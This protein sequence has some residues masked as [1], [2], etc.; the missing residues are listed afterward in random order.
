[1]VVGKVRL[2]LMI[3]MW[4]GGRWRGGG[5]HGRECVRRGRQRTIVHGRGNRLTATNN[6]GRIPPTVAV[7]AAAAARE[8]RGVVVNQPPSSLC[9]S[10]RGDGAR[11]SKD[12]RDLPML[13]QPHRNLAWI[14]PDS[15]HQL[16]CADGC[17]TF[18]NFCLHARQN[19]RI[20]LA[21]F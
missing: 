7:T 17:G 5:P 20:D 10:K 15:K 1:M 14:S 2:M 12:Q 13:S 11:C 4:W 18:A 3:G 19:N 9:R 8:E 16:C 21:C 6:C